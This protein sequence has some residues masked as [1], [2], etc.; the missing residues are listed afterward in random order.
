MHFDKEDILKKANYF[1]EEVIDECCNGMYKIVLRFNPLQISSMRYVFYGRRP[2][3][4]N[5]MSEKL[6]ES[7]SLEDVLVYIKTMYP[8]MKAEDWDTL[9]KLEKE[10]EEATAMRCISSNDTTR[11]KEDDA[12]AAFC[13][14]VETHGLNKKETSKPKIKKV[15]K[16]N[17]VTQK[18]V[19][20]S[21]K[22]IHWSTPVWDDLTKYDVYN[23]PHENLK[24]VG[25]VP[26]V[27]RIDGLLF[28]VAPKASLEGKMRG[29]AFKKSIRGLAMCMNATVVEVK[30]FSDKDSSDII[31]YT[32]SIDVFGSTVYRFTKGSV[33]LFSLRKDGN[34]EKL[35]KF[36]PDGGVTC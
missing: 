2:N 6:F 25:F 4:I 1:R 21:G 17:K 11:K 19:Q 7:I 18:T 29:Q 26:L 16:T 24:D 30:K 13:E 31:E 9:S 34:W 27:A 15:N 5:G 36:S 3:D 33:F 28:W 23:V 8:E 12:I 35:R 32:E 10:A 14:F 22:R 20:K